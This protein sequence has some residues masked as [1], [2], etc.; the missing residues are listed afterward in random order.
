MIIH[1][2][3]YDAQTDQRVSVND[4]VG[5]TQYLA[6]RFWSY[7]WPQIRDKRIKTKVWIF[8]PSVRIES[9]KWAFELVFGEAPVDA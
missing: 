4:I 1:D 3:V 7:Y 6:S 9:L 2:M 8:R 5:L